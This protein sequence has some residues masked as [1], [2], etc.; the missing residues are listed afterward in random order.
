MVRVP[1]VILEKDG[2]SILGKFLKLN[3]VSLSYVD[4]IDNEMDGLRVTFSKFVTAPKEG[5]KIKLYLGFDGVVDDMGEFY[6]FGVREYYQPLL[7]AQ[8]RA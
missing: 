1:T 7:F 4:T 3:L 6:P 2:S 8:R 5:D